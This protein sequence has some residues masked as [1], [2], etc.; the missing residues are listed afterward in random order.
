MGAKPPRGCCCGGCGCFLRKLGSWGD[1]REFH[2]PL[3]EASVVLLQEMSCRESRARIELLG[4]TTSSLA[5][6]SVE[7]QLSKDRTE[8]DE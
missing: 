1:H 6:S 7:S 3:S 5:H 4:T 2:P 8:S